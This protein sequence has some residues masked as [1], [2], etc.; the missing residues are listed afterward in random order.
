MS[1]PP[2][3]NHR[4]AIS[5][6]VFFSFSRDDFKSNSQ[7]WRGTGLSALNYRFELVFSLPSTL[8]RLPRIIAIPGI[9][10][11][12]LCFPPHPCQRKPSTS[13]KIRIHR[14]WRTE[15]AKWHRLCSFTDC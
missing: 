14:I 8:L 9:L 12:V 5:H 3:A 11:G 4:S 13:W 15:L 2:M 6:I 1:P 7:V 10:A